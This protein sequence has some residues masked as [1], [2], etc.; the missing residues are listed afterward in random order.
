MKISVW[1]LSSIAKTKDVHTELASVGK[2]TIDATGTSDGIYLTGKDD[3]GHRIVIQLDAAE[4]G[5]VF[6]LD[7]ERPEPFD[8]TDDVVEDAARVAWCADGEGVDTWNSIRSEDRTWR[9]R[10]ARAVLEYAAGKIGAPHKPIDGKT[11]ASSRVYRPSGDPTRIPLL[12]ECISTGLTEEQTINRLS[13]A[14]GVLADDLQ[15]CVTENRATPPAGP[16]VAERL[17]AYRCAVATGF[18]AGGK[19]MTRDHVEFE[20]HG[21]LAAESTPRAATDDRAVR[22]LPDHTEP[23]ANSTK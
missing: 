16:S 6:A 1:L 20:A 19:A 7:A 11:R 5:R 12:C 9:L 10:E 4:V 18:L 3:T 23:R 8:V 15:R 14:L 13:Q 21:M 17:V 2:I 22:Q